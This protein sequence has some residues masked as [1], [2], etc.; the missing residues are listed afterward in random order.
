MRIR[1][2]YDN[3]MTNVSAV[4]Q[5]VFGELVKLTAPVLTHYH[6]DLYHDALWLAEQCHGAEVTFRYSF[7]ESGTV[8]G[9]GMAHM[10]KHAYRITVG[11]TDGQ[12]WMDSEP[13]TKEG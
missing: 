1:L 6:S 5:L 10:R 7:D 11:V 4:R 13:I 3:T 12:A 8:I 2:S 9:G